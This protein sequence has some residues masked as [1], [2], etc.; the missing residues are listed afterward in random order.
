MSGPLDGARAVPS[1]R[2]LAAW[3]VAAATVARLLV[4]ARLPLGNGEAY[5]YSWSR[6]LDW[7]YYDHPPLVAWMVRAHHRVRRGALARAAAVHLGP[8]LASGAFGLLFHRLAERLVRPRA[9]LLALVVVTALPVFL[10]SSFIVN[11][12]APLAPLWVACLLAILAMRDHDEP[13]RPLVAGLLLGFAFLAKYTAILLVPAS[14]V[15]VAC[16]PAMRRWLRRPSFYAGGL[17]ALF[18]ALPVI[19]WN[20]ARGW[21]SIRLHFVERAGV[22][23]PVAGENTVNQ[24]VAISSSSGS[25]FLQGVARVVV[26]QLMS[27]SPLLA[28][29]LVLGL[30]RA[31]RRVRT[32]DRDLFVSAFTWPVLLPLLAAMVVLKDAEQHWTMV[33]FIPAAIA[34]GRAVDEGWTRSRRLP[35]LASLGV[36]LSA[37]AFVVA[38][39]HAHSTVLLDLI[40]ANKYDPRADM[41]N[42]LAGWDQ[43]SAAMKQ[44]ARGASG[45]VVLAS[46]HYSLCGR[47]LYETNDS[48]PTYCPTARRSAYAFFGRQD[49]PADA[50]VITLTSDIH[51]ELPAGLRG[52]ECSVVDSIDVQR[53]GRDV[54]HYLVRS[55]APPL[56][57]RQRPRRAAAVLRPGSRVRASPH[58]LPVP[59]FDGLVDGKARVE[60]RDLIGRH[61]GRGRQ[62]QDGAVVEGAIARVAGRPLGADDD[63]AAR[64]AL[65]SHLLVETVAHADLGDP[66]PEEASDLDGREH[67]GHHRRPSRDPLPD[68]RTQR[69]GGRVPSAAGEEP[70][71][72]QGRRQV[73]RPRSVVGVG[74]R[75]EEHGHV[76]RGDGHGEVAHRPC[77]ATPRRPPRAPATATSTVPGTVHSIVNE[78]STSRWLACSFGLTR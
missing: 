60:R 61:L 23:V 18:I 47:L 67:D 36:G 70:D 14:L 17:T 5:Y 64:D 6:F 3:W 46:N 8:V 43:V 13:Y 10:A 51:E 76:D 71:R 57:Q 26:G 45:P 58:D 62:V 16:S 34:A 7:S 39:V 30:A 72:E 31:L 73:A 27:Y 4:V 32:D 1:F 19:A 11:P 37:L 56:R 49:P 68:E 69:G 75:H 2:V 77:G 74:D 52:R 54:A 50:T 21:P 35:V 53:G 25:G 12:E 44:A 42:E 22:S 20:M 48:P 55:C 28:P 40:P 78:R 24:L 33:A 66:A 9:A 29:L 59:A 41:I 65:L 63:D 38:N 15:Y